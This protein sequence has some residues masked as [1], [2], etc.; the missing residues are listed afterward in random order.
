[1]RRGNRLFQSLL[2]GATAV[3]FASTAIGLFAWFRSETSI[4]EA[5]V[6]AAIWSAFL[7]A[8]IV[9]FWSYFGRTERG[10]GRL[11]AVA[12]GLSCS[13]GSLTFASAMW[14]MRSN[15]TGYQT[16]LTRANAG[17]VIE[18]VAQF[19]K[20]INDVAD[21]MANVAATAASKGDIETANGGTCEGVKPQKDCGPICRLRK[22]QQND[23]SK[24]SNELSGVAQESTD[25]ISSIQA[26]LS[27]EG[28]TKGYKQAG[29]LARHR[30]LTNARIWIDTQLHGFDTKFVDP[31]S[32]SAF[33]CRDPAFRDQLALAR[34][35]LDTDLSLPSIPPE[36]AT[37]GYADAATKS[38]NDV[39]HL[40]GAAFTLSM[41]KATQ[42]SLQDNAAGLGIAAFI[43]LVIIFL[44]L[45]ETRDLRESEALETV[46]ERFIFTD[47]RMPR[48]QIER[49][50]ELSRFVDRFTFRSN[51]MPELLFLRPLDGR[52]DTVAKCSDIVRLFELPYSK[53]QVRIINRDIVSDWAD[54]NDDL[55][56]GARTF[57]VRVLTKQL[58]RQL[59]II[60]RDTL[61]LPSP[62][63]NDN[64]APISNS[65]AL[66]ARE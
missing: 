3:S 12:L 52:P 13:L 55:T 36:P 17:T 66:A 31:Q 56:D 30:A 34:K 39:M 9:A 16:T 41:N 58:D 19:S 44:V 53:R 64:P 37:V 49:L 40:V 29:L 54:L 21:T 4:L 10:L 6:F 61:L 46:A 42:Q 35:I 63:G 5:V 1:M 25:L 60:A 32:G 2:W 47:R 43:E 59:R 18:P 8:G 65:R 24:L 11:F 28:L 7:Q 14:L 20:R 62:P 27:R 26:D 33:I 23:A 48:G 15:H 45:A 38:V 51:S 50:A 22:R 57:E